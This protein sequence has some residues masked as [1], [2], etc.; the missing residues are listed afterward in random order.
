MRADFDALRN[1]Y[2]GL[3][4]PTAVIALVI[5]TATVCS[6]Y[7]SIGSELTTTGSRFGGNLLG[8]FKFEYWCGFLDRNTRKLCTSATFSISSFLSLIYLV[9]DIGCSN[10]WS[11]KICFRLDIRAATV[12]T[13]A[14]WQFYPKTDHMTLCC[15]DDTYCYF[16]E[17]VIN[18]LT[19]IRHH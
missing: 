14:H 9:L 18:Q 1:G 16:E 13:A 4:V 6:R 7:P 11:S 19:G 15:Y 10:N 2:L 17:N 8:N 3:T 5:A 12:W